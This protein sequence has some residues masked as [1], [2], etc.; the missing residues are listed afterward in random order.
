MSF[1]TRS[2]GCLAFEDLGLIFV[3]YV[4]ATRPRSSL[5]LNPK[6]VPQA[7][8]GDSTMDQSVNVEFN[9]Q[10]A[11]K[12]RIANIADYQFDPVETFDR[13]GLR[14]ISE[15]VEKKPRVHLAIHGAYDERG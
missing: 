7:L 9:E 4:T 8:T 3:S 15:L 14:S 10:I 11:Y 2:A 13:L 6:S 12:H 5:I 1:T